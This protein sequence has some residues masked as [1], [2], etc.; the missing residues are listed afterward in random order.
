MVR[1][2]K[3]VDAAVPQYDMDKLTACKKLGLRI[4][5]SVMIGME[6]KNGKIMKRSLKKKE[7]KSSISHTQRAFLQQN[8]PQNLR[9]TQKIIIKAKAE[10]KDVIG[11][12]K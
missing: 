5:L 3:Y 10:S 2:C 7:L 9:R 8:L 6:P 11:N 1:S 4:F 12:N